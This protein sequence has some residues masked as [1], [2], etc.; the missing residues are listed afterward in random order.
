MASTFPKP[1]Q[2]PMPVASLVAAHSVAPL[3]VVGDA[4]RMIGSVSSPR[5]GNPDSL[6]FVDRKDSVGLELIRSSPAGIIVA[7]A[8][9]I[10]RV[11]S[12]AC[13]IGADDPRAWY[14][15]ALNILFPR[16]RHAWIA[17]TAMISRDA[18]VG[19]NV[20]IGHFAVI[21]DGVEIGEGSV[22]GDHTTVKEGT[23]IGKGCVIQAHAVIGSEGVAFHRT[24]DEG[25][26]HCFPHQ[27][28]VHIG[29]DVRIG[30]STCI[31]RG[32]LDDTVIGSGCKIGNFVNIAHN[33]WLAE[34]CWI[35]SNVLLCG[36][37]K[38][39]AD[40]RLA[41]SVSINSRVRIGR[42]AQVGLG[43]VVLKDVPP[44]VSVFGNPAKPLRTM[45]PI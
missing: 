38:L 39:E 36:A 27:G 9:I 20:R 6:A 14:I 42:G 31:V 29:D 25:P 40:V 3:L 23:R 28:N 34:N 5:N 4:S 26:W 44:G 2:T 33:C 30:V 7:N 8:V 35:S 37:V 43:S 11:L 17:P 1:L 10:D 32:M 15:G 13:L 16:P 21:E 18:T 24:G 19:A 12:K 22:V 45:R 41:A